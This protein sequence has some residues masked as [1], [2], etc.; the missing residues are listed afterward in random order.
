MSESE[1]YE[2]AQSKIVDGSKFNDVSNYQDAQSRIVDGSKYYSVSNYQDAQS[3]IN[4]ISKKDISKGNNESSIYQ[5]AQSKITINT[6]QNKKN[7]FSNMNLERN[8]SELKKEFIK[9]NIYND[10]INENNYANN[11]REKESYKKENYERENFEKENY[12]KENNKEEE[13]EYYEPDIDSTKN[14]TMFEGASQ[15]GGC[16]NLPKC[17]I[18]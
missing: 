17:F 16:C 10:E 11:L 7:S 12:E 18:F 8:E 4:N 6:G 13:S 15:K 14:K 5:D 1:I 3:R 2:D 9:H